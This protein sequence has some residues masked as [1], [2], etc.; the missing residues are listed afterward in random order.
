MAWQPCPP[1]RV[2]SSCWLAPAPGRGSPPRHPQSRGGVGQGR[3]EVPPP[4]V[5]SLLTSVSCLPPSG[6]GIHRWLRGRSGRPPEVAR[7]QDLRHPAPGE[8]CPLA[9]PL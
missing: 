7:E 5:S 2:S 6:I 4:H 8:R 1:G 3:S 9:S